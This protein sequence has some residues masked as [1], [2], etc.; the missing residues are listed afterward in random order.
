MV[1]V[2]ID[3]TFVLDKYTYDVLRFRRVL[4]RMRE[5]HVVFP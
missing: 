2:D 4:S 5:A 3:G 1:A